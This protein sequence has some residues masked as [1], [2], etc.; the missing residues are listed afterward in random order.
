MSHLTIYEFIERDNI[1]VD[2]LYVD[3]VLQDKWICINDD[4]IKS[5]GCAT[6]R[7]LSEHLSSEDFKENKDYKYI[8]VADLDDSYAIFGDGQKPSNDA[9]RYLIAVSP[10]CFQELL[11]LINTTDSKMIHKD[12]LYAELVYKQYMKYLSQSKDD[13]LAKLQNKLSL[14]NKSYFKYEQY[15]YVMT[16]SNDACKNIFKLG[17]A[18]SDKDLVKSNTHTSLEYVYLMNCVDASSLYQM[19]MKWLSPFRYNDIEDLFQIHFAT[20]KKLLSIFENLESE[21][22][23]TINDLYS[24]YHISCNDTLEPFE[25]K[26]L[27]NCNLHGYCN[28]LYNVDLLDADSSDYGSITAIDN[29]TLRSF[30]I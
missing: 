5:I 22:F 1:Q 23:A 2:K 3:I 28:K 17:F 16:K 6:I 7:D 27:V 26:D 18:I 29:D 20:L 8:E 13:E 9:I 24:D 12:Y 15:V 14:V 10:I 19:I 4:L 21:L 25:F 30:I 11:A